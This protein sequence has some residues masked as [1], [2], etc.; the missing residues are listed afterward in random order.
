MKAMTQSGY[1]DGDEPLTT[2]ERRRLR[3]TVNV[4]ALERWL[5]VSH[6]QL[7]RATIAHF[8]SEITADDLAEVRREAG[9]AADSDSESAA[10]ME[11]EDSPGLAEAQSFH[12]EGRAFR[13]RSTYQPVVIVSPPTDPT[14]RALWD[15]IEPIREAV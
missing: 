5:A 13:F 6:G 8:A 1:G 4:V 11:D 12:L 7:R 2:L 10:S 14:L 3:P 15:A 9:M